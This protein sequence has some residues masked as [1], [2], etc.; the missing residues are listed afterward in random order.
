MPKR[1][2]HVVPHNG[3]WAVRREGSRR[4][5]SRHD[6]QRE[7]IEAARDIARNQ[8]GE[9]I[10]H[11]RNGHIR[12]G[13]SH[14]VDPIPPRDHALMPGRISSREVDES[15]EIIEDQELDEEIRCAVRSGGYQDEDSVEIVRRSRAEK[16][17]QRAA[18]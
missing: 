16:N 6:T 15:L 4:V 11:T 14:G 10:I 7:A 18:S 9:L 3:A 8:G 5:T 13:G 17:R 1:N 12:S 2:Q